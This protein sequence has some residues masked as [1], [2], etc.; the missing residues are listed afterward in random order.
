MQLIGR[1]AIFMFAFIPGL[2]FIILGIDLFIDNIKE[3]ASR[4][5]EHFDL[6]WLLF[7]FFLIIGGL[8]FIGL[9]ISVFYLEF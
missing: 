7:T 5:F 8:F 9:G 2:L 3:I 4:G 1:I 6:W